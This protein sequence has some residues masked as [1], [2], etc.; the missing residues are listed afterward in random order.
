MIENCLVKHA[1][2]G[3]EISVINWSANRQF[4]FYLG[5][6]CAVI[7]IQVTPDHTIKKTFRPAVSHL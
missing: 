1:C 5:R 7:L 3:A 6:Q 4:H 2:I